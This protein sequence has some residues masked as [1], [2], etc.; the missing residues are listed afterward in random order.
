MSGNK[1]QIAVIGLGRFGTAVAE[2]LSKAGHEV[3]GI[4]SDRNIV[5]K[6]AT[7]IP[8]A[9]QVD[10]VDE[11]ALRQLGIESYDAAVVGITANLQYFFLNG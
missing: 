1:Q 6:I 5:Q 9:V 8:H 4:D 2:E 7:K 3:I 11:N 10:A